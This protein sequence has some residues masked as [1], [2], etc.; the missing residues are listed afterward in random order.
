MKI[1]YFG[2]VC[3]MRNYE[4]KMSEFRVKP[5]IASIVFEKALTEG[6]SQNKADMDIFTFPIIPAFPRSKYLFLKPENETLECGYESRWLG[7]VNVSGLKQ[8]CLRLASR[9]AIKNWIKK[10]KDEK[11]AILIYSI[12]EPVAKSIVECAKEYNVPCFAIVSDLPADMYRLA[13]IGKIKKKLSEIYVRNVR[14]IQGSFD[15]YIY[16]TEQMKDVI[17]KSAPYIVVEGIADLSDINSRIKEKADTKYIMYAGTLNRLFG[18][19]NLIEA[20]EG[21]KNNDDVEL[22]LFGTG[23]YTEEI[24]KRAAENE[25]IKYFGRRTREE[26]LEYEKK[27]FLLVNVRSCREEFTQFSFP[28][29]TIEYMLSGTPMLTTK[30]KG[31]PEEYFKYVFVIEDNSPEEIQKKL[32]EIIGTDRDE[33]CT[34][35]QKAQNFIKENKNGAVQAKKIMDFIERHS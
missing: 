14:K 24:K 25:K 30:L 33:L 11:K 29:K 16:L 6:F 5:S 2:T 17:N 7:S 1:L 32:E 13:K 35:G 27:A 15:G 9:R 21:L 18:V 19:G 34:M 26:I 3:N 4:K 31:I 23:D 10:N 20:F 28:S 22:W 12:Y 8:K